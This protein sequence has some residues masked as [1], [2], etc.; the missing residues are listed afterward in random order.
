MRG[1]KP[2]SPSQIKK[3][4]SKKTWFWP[5]LYSSLAI[6]FVALFWGYSA[7]VSQ[8]SSNLAGKIN[9]TANKG[10][11]G[12][13]TVETNAENETIKYPFSETLLEDVQVL[14]G[15]YDLE[16][17][18]A[19]RESSLLVFNQ[20]YVTNTGVTLSIDNKPFEVVAAMGG[21]V[22]EVIT[23]VF[24]GDEIIISHPN[25]LKTVYR[26]V[27]GILVKKGDEIEQGQ[28]IGVASDNEWNPTAGTHLHFEVHLQNEP[29]N[30]GSYLAF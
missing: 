30:P 19:M 6:F 8:D 15:F 29:V 12:E 25:D 5:V 26:S 3:K 11:E 7:Y 14:Q 2:K 22:E 9:K 16:A 21:V 20:T 13:L 24:K 1:E 28:A 18:E 4:Y 23:D 10:E 27:T 17:D